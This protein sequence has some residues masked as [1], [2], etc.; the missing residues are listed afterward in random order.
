MCF[1]LPPQRGRPM[2]FISS[3]RV[4]SA[5]SKFN[6]VGG[7]KSDHYW[8]ASEPVVVSSSNQ[9]CFAS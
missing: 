9:Y 2:P 5:L 4:M 8:L 1:G 3:V 6:V 7:G